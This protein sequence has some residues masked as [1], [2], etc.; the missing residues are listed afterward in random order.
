[1]QEEERM[2][3]EKTK[4]AHLATHPHGEGTNKRKRTNKDKATA[5][6]G[7]SQVNAQQKQDKGPTYYFCKKAGHM[8]ECPKYTKWL[9][10][11][12][13]FFLFSLF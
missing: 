6:A 5:N 13:D 12:C 9:A 8:K 11:I 3:Q 4:S 1:M 2:R 10:K 7:T